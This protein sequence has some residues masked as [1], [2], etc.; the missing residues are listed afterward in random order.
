MI[1]LNVYNGDIFGIST[2]LEY[3]VW[4][5]PAIIG[6][7]Y[8]KGFIT[9]LKVYHTLYLGVIVLIFWY[10]ESPFRVNKKIRHR[11]EYYDTH[12]LMC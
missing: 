12:A 9:S 10:F 3:I 4:Y 7:I 8:K 2:D 11:T 5:I 1:V 6:A